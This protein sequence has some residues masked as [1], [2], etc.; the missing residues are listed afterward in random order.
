MSAR[1]IIVV[2]VVF[3]AL[4]IA[5]FA[6][7]YTYYEISDR[8]INSSAFNESSQAQQAIESGRTVANRT[9]YILF[10][11]FMAMCFVIIIT[12][13]FVGGDPIFSFIYFIVI[14]LAV[15]VAA[16]LNNVWVGFTE[17]S[18]FLVDGVLARFP[19]VDHMMSHLPLYAAIVGF[20]GLIAMFAKSSITGESR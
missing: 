9:D 8:M 14:V 11:V 5:F 16:V 7:N 3:F 10:I 2:I 15:V 20:L 13:W 19:I 17:S 12:G 4:A 6:I 18:I 1:D